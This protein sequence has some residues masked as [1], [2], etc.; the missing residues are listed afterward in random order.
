MYDYLT[1]KGIS[2]IFCGINP[3]VKKMLDRADFENKIGNEA[4][5]SDVI[6]AIHMIEKK[7]FINDE[8]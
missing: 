1:G 8:I 7:V 6:A 5:V 4:I 3:S 2:V